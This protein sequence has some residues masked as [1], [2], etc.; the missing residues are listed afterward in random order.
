MTRRTVSTLAFLLLFIPWF[1]YYYGYL[2]N[3]EIYVAA[4]PHALTPGATGETSL[5][6]FYQRDKSMVLYP[7]WTLL[8]NYQETD[9]SPYWNPYHFGG[10]PLLSQSSYL[11]PLRYFLTWLLSS[12][13]PAHALYMLAMMIRS[14]IAIFGIYLVLRHYKINPLCSAAATIAF[15]YCAPILDLHSRTFDPLYLW[16]I[17]LLLNLKLWS[18]PT[19]LRKVPYALGIAL[20]IAAE[21][22]TWHLHFAMLFCIFLSVFN[23]IIALR[24]YRHL[25]WAVMATLALFAG[26]GLLATLMGSFRVWVFLDHLSYSYRTVLPKGSGGL[27]PYIPFGSMYFPYLTEFQNILSL[28][29][30]VQLHPFH[31]ELKRVIGEFDS[32]T[33][34]ITFYPIL[35]TLGQIGAAYRSP[36]WY[37]LLVFLFI[38]PKTR[39]QAYPFWS[40]FL[41]IFSA[42]NLVALVSPIFRDA[43]PDILKAGN[44]SYLV[45]TATHLSLSF[46]FSFGVIGLWRLLRQTTRESGTMTTDLRRMLNLVR[47]RGSQKSLLATAA[48]VVFGLIS[49]HLLGTQ[50]DTVI[51]EYLYGLVKRMHLGTAPAIFS[52]LIRGQYPLAYYHWKV[53]IFYDALLILLKYLS[54]VVLPVVAIAWIIVSIKDD[55]RRPGLRFLSAKTLCVGTALLIG[56]GITYLSIGAGVSKHAPY[57]G[58]ELLKGMV[59]SELD[60]DI[61]LNTSQLFQSELGS[62]YDPLPT[63]CLLLL[64]TTLAGL[65]L[66]W[67]MFWNPKKRSPAICALVLLLAFEGVGVTI[68]TE[69]RSESSSLSPQAEWLTFLRGNIGQ[70]RYLAFGNA[71]LP[72]VIEHKE[73]AAKVYDLGLDHLAVKKYGLLRPSSDL[74]YRLPHLE[75]S[76][77]LVSNDYRLF[78]YASATDIPVETLNWEYLLRGRTEMTFPF[79]HSLAYDLLSMKYLVTQHTLSDTHMELVY[80]KGVRI[81][82][83]KRALPRAWLAG[84]MEVQPDRIKCLERLRDIDLKGTVLLE[85]HPVTPSGEST[86]YGWSH[87]LPARKGE[88]VSFKSMDTRQLWSLDAIP[89][90]SASFDISPSSGDLLLGPT[91]PGRVICTVST[92][93]NQMLVFSENFYPGWQATLDGKPSDIYRADYALMAVP[94]PAGEHTIEIFFMPPSYETAS[95]ISFGSLS[96]CIGML[97]LFAFWGWKVKRGVNSHGTLSSKPEKEVVG[98]R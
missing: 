20:A 30:K 8:Q 24:K 25:R 39:R 95:L 13:L 45:V 82:E 48:I 11:D 28:F 66:I 89:E 14:A 96:G 17:A 51:K 61:S 50:F 49:V 15:W 93:T 85:K 41:S 63:I 84:R 69:E 43:F 36:I 88:Y 31:P 74:L 6:Q 46:C 40:S 55:V 68:D 62:L 37:L 67:M 59:K 75:G 90:Q 70:H 5:K 60:Q 71:W 3:G 12:V 7:E 19:F 81:Y 38:E 83:N 53:D 76:S 73:N 87:S 91:S 32:S 42:Y 26:A 56:Y 4:T 9:A 27:V 77:P 21:M 57:L 97:L 52:D 72:K 34:S 98:P 64:A 80:D 35:K 86:R 79:H 65:A 54:L 18:E 44:W 22:Y 92:P 58:S 1:T 2:I 29:T 78:T 33:V 94:V 10:A 47:S 23:I 16:I